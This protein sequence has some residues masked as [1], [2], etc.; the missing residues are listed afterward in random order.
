MTVLALLYALAATV[1]TALRF[2]PVSAVRLFELVDLGAWLGFAPLMLLVPL[3]LI[4]RRWHALALLMVPVTFFSLEYGPMFVPNSA[5][6]G[7]GRLRIV[8]ANLLFTNRDIDGMVEMFERLDA[9]VVALHELSG[10]HAEALVRRMGDRY[11]HRVLHPE[12]HA[13]GMGLMSRVRLTEVVTPM[14][15]RD[16]CSCHAVTTTVGGQQVTIVNAHP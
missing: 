14:L 3:A 5:P 15:G 7:A 10:P 12:P 11:P 1:W 4:R 2:T 16:D 13:L 6:E 8:T 9:D